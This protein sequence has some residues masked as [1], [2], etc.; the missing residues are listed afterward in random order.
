MGDHEN[1]GPG[2]RHQSGGVQSDSLRQMTGIRLPA[3]L[4]ARFDYERHGI[5]SSWTICRTVSVGLYEMTNVD[6]SLVLPKAL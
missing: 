2:T 4:L 3:T 6:G 5:P 1:T